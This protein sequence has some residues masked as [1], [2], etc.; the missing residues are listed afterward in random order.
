MSNSDYQASFTHEES[1][2][3]HVKVQRILENGFMIDDKEYHGTVFINENEVI[4][5]DNITSHEDLSIE[6]INHILAHTKQSDM[7]LIGCG[8]SFKMWQ[9]GI[10]VHI[11]KHGLAFEYM[12]TRSAIDSLTILQAED[13]HVSAI[14]LPI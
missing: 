1:T 2:I 3:E 8:Q 6:N 5:L 10:D 12:N 14:L 4:Q 7:L 9:K 11:R 13:R